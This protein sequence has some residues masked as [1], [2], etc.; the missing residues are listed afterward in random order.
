MS[1][2]GTM[3][4]WLAQLRG[5]RGCE[6]SA[7]SRNGE[8]MSW[9]MWPF[10]EDTALLINTGFAYPLKAEMARRNHRIAMSFT[11]CEDGGPGAP[12]LLV[13]GDAQV[14]DQDLQANTDRYVRYLLKNGPAAFRLLLRTPIRRLLG[15]YLVRIWVR[16]KPRRIYRLG[17]GGAELVFGPEPASR[18]D[19]AAFGSQ[20]AAAGEAA[21]G[22]QD[23]SRAVEWSSEFSNVLLTL[24]DA[25]GYPFSLRAAF[26]WTGAELRLEGPDRLAAASGKACILF[27]RQAGDLPKARTFALRGHLRQ[28]GVFT[29]R[30]LVGF[31]GRATTRP[32]GPSDFLPLRRALKRELAV[33]G[34]AMPELRLPAPVEVDAPGKRRQV[35]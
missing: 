33:K 24:V 11:D 8:P 13:Q 27:H 26:A 3:E 5:Y 30:K 10:F 21:I 9:A 6:Y 28:G 23:L 22:K 34:R 32:P 31:L 20:H 16:L 14:L 25:D 29:P 17:D 15:F 2:S 12:A 7:V 4:N 1:A 35:I 19:D 18:P